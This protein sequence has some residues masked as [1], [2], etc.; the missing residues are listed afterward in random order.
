MSAK[1]R[2]MLLIVGFV[3]LVVLM[4]VTRL[5]TDALGVVVGITLGLAAT[6][7]ALVLLAWL[8]GRNSAA[9]P[10]P[11]NGARWGAPP[12]ESLPYRDRRRLPARRAQPPDARERSITAPRRERGRRADAPIAY[13]DRHPLRE[14]I[15]WPPEDAYPTY[16][17]YAMID[18][19]ADDAADLW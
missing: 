2:L 6:V 4:V 11:D 7:P 13:D 9:Q 14:V 19:A 16:D 3:G 15:V 18:D 17:D 5:S 10:P 1:D 8:A 12:Y